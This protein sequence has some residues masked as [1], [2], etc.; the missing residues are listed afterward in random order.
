MLLLLLNKST[1]FLADLFFC[2]ANIHSVSGLEGKKLLVAAQTRSRVLCLAFQ[3][4]AFY[5]IFVR[6]T[7]KAN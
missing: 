4:F 3:F 2:T 5:L 6:Q 7:N 1:A